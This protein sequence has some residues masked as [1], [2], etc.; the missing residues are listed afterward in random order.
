MKR[1]YAVSMIV[2]STALIFACSTGNGKPMPRS[3]PVVAETAD[4][5]NVPL[6]V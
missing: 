6:Q 3:V 2:S 4:Q 5:K 1:A